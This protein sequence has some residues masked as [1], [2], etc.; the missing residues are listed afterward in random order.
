MGSRRLEG[1]PQILL[2]LS[3]KPSTDNVKGPALALKDHE[4]VSVGIGVGDASRSELELIAFDPGLTYKV[5][6]FSK[7]PSIHSQLVAAL[8]N[9]DEEAMTGISDLVVELESPQRDI[10]F[11]LDGSDDTRSDFTAMKGFVQKVVE[12][13]SVGENKDRV[14][15]VQYSREPQTHFSLNTYTEKQDILKALQELNH[16]G[17]KPLNTGAA[18]NYVRN[19]AFVDSSGSRHQ[20]GIPQ[21]LILLSEGR[22]QDDVA[23][24][25]EALKQDKIVPF[26]IGTRNADILELQMIAHNP[27]YAFSVL[28]FDDIGS[29]HQQLVSFM[30]RLPRQQPR[31]K[32][33][34]VLGSTD[35]AESIQRDVVFL[36][37]SSNEMRN[38]FQAMLGFVERMVE[39]LSVDENKDRISVVQY[40]REP[41]VEFFLNTYKTQQNVVDNVRS[42]RHKGGTPLNTGAALQYIKDNVFTASSGSRHQHGVPQILVLLIG[43]RTSDDVRNAVENLKGIGVMVFVVGTKNAN[44]FEIQSISQEASHAF[45]AVDYSDMSGIEQQIFSAIQKGETPAV[46]PTSYGKTTVTRSYAACT[47]SCIVR[48]R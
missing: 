26:C 36:L 1:V 9:G 23:S 27:S 2:L 17:G 29:I 6:D 32:S 22:S 46:K 42:L 19:N 18:L 39:K 24:A 43:G 35:Q 41:S 14:S 25:A 3:S 11:L 48:L 12:T 16:Q 44:T 15:V 34:I 45:F 30:K 33:Q 5:T 10:V 8:N 4:I 37:D 47:T 31:L 21:I 28:G 20:E 7:L 13:L 40:S 38:E